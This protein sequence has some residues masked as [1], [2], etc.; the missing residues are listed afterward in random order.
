[1]VP[2]IVGNLIDQ[3]GGEAAP[4]LLIPSD[5]LGE[6][7]M[8]KLPWMPP[9]TKD[10]SGLRACHPNTHASSPWVPWRD[11]TTAELGALCIVRHAPVVFSAVLW[12][13]GAEE[14]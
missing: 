7:V 8:R 12:C 13:F 9:L 10:V 14:I 6:G 5:S 3:C 1:M 2:F 11:I 4:F